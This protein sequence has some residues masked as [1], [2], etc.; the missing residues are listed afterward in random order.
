MLSSTLFIPLVCVA[1]FAATA[2]LTGL[3]RRALMGRA[4]MDRPNER[5][6]HTAPVPRGGGLAVMLVVLGGMAVSSPA[7]GFTVSHVW[8]LLAVFLLMGVSWLDDCRPVGIGWRFG[9]HLAA[10]LLGSLALPPDSFLLNGL[11]PFWAERLLLIVGW[12]WFMNLTNFM[13]GID[14]ITCVEIVSIAVGTGLVL[15]VTATSDPFL[16]ILIALM[17][18]ACSGFLLFNWHPA[19]IFLGDV[20]SVP[21]GFLTGYLLLALAAHGFRA[22]ALVLPL[23]YLADSG[24]TLGRR[25]LRG[26]KFW[27]P[28]RQHYYQRAAQGLKRHDK[29][30]LWIAITN[31]ALVVAALLAIFVPLAGIGLAVAAVALLLYRMHI[32]SPR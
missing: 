16:L 19:R 13:D 23:Y 24:I 15:S 32:S 21:L 27:Q 26:E 12:A 10:A 11:L 7:F 22:A 9:A 17:I 31:V 28:H 20:G 2:A 14:G 4:I 8:L 5:S 1:A 25:V 3:V 18:G 29:V 6:M 30:V